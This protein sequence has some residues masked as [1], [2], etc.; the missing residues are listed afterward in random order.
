MINP[1]EENIEV[2][3]LPSVFAMSFGFHTKSK[4]NS[5]KSK[6]VFDH[7]KLQRKEHQQN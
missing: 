2:I 7:I 4:G 3:F 6:Q 1:L 5:Y